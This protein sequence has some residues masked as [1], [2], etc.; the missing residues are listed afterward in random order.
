MAPEAW[1]AIIGSAGAAI[2]GVIVAFSGYRRT[3]TTQIREDLQEC[4]REQ[5]RLRRKL[6]DTLHHAGRLEDLL[7]MNRIKV[8]AR[9]PSLV[10]ELTPIEPANWQPRHAETSSSAGV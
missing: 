1:A 5:E 6:H 9:P 8:P 10:P 3:R 4:W 2:S 7:S